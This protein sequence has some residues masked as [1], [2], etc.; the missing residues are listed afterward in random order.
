M[1][2]LSLT[3]E[4]W[5]RVPRFYIL[6]NQDQTIS[7]TAQR[8]MIARA[9]PIEV[10]ELAGDHMANMTHAEELADILTDVADRYPSHAIS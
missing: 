3:Q 10:V 9:Q 6:M 7:P 2:P 8:A 5:G 1:Q 4:N